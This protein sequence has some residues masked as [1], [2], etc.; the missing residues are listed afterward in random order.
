MNIYSLVKENNQ[1]N[2]QKTALSITMDNGEQ[3]SYTYSDLIKK[4]DTYANRLVSA[5]IYSGDR[6]AIVAENSPEWDIAYLAVMKIRS[7]AVLIDATLAKDDI[8]ELIKKSDIRCIYTSPKIL[9]KLDNML[10]QEIP[11][12]NLLNNSEAFDNYSSKVAVSAPK[13]PDGDE[14]IAS[15][16]YS[17]G[18]TRTAAEIM[19]THEAL[20]K[21]TLMCAENNKLTS[22][23]KYLSIIPNSHIYGF[24]CLVLGPMLLG[25]DVHY[26][27]SMNNDT[28]IAAFNE[29]KPTVFPC[30]P[31]V[32]E[33]FKTQIIRKIESEK[34]TKKLFNLFFPICLKLRK[35]F[36]VNLGKLLFKSIH[37]G[38]GGKIDILC[39]AGAPMDIET[40]EFYLGTGFNLLITYGATETNIPTIGN[41]GN[42]LTTDSCGKPY[43]NVEIKL[44]DTGELLI[45]SPYMMKGYFRDD[46]TTNDA[47]EDGWFKTGDL[48]ALDEKGN[49]KVI[50]R[51]KENIV[52]AT[53]KKISPDDVERKYA[54]IRGIKEF[55]V[56]GVPARNGSHDEIHAFVVRENLQVSVDKLLKDIQDRSSKLTQY[57]KI[58]NVHF[59]DNILKTSLQKPKRY[60]LKKLAMEENSKQT[61][62]ILSEHT[63][64]YIN[65]EV[66]I[67]NLIAKVGELDRTMVFTHSKP[68]SALGIDSLS[69]IDLALQIENKYG[70]RVDE[71][72]SQDITISEIINL[73]KEPFEGEHKSNNAFVYPKTKK[74]G[75][76][77]LFRYFCSIARSLYKITIRNDKVIPDDSGYIICANHVSNFDYLWL[78][79][80]FKKE[81]FFKFCC[82]AKNEIF[83]NSLASRLLSQVCG[84]IPVNR[85]NANIDAMNCCKEKLKEKWG[86][87]IHPEGT[88]SNNGEL[89]E[90]KKGAAVLAIES[91][92]PII[93]AYIKGA[94]EIYPKGKKLPK[95]FNF[96]I[97]KKYPVEVTYGNPIF[98][99]NLTAE[100]LIKQVEI[101]ILDL[102]AA[103]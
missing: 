62:E 74:H 71:Y 26:I 51:C 60:L 31:K 53:G 18:T 16:I 11:V 66:E 98:P 63:P 25:A 102:Q 85:G 94:Y 36:G 93:P 47:F 48:G 35:K 64:S 46:T 90:L 39:S 89:G 24:I 76:Y 78:T 57:I 67:I 37:K 20:I 58:S 69:A 52:L 32:F 54:D 77:A 82:M 19:H 91:N 23:G 83:N 38:F 40:A 28:I 49:Y 81:R 103:Y 56:C 92:V 42:N 75:D 79:V 65:L 22:S 34:K 99:K 101:S 95:L 72:F 5:N 86:L 68:F 33:L 7:T 30:V 27:E 8:L 73:I 15:I 3:R 88:R 55:V 44:S 97:M 21:S 6:V 41:R 80:N 14:S 50:G 84:M 61:E 10:P 2:G 45:K 17:S 59:V 70:V 100:E 43:S 12:L 1:S 29:Y 87:L 96:R 4:V 9:E 13:T